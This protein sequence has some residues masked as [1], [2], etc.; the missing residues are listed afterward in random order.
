MTKMITKRSKLYVPYLYTRRKDKSIPVYIKKK[1]GGGAYI[2]VS[3]RTLP[4]KHMFPKNKQN[5]LRQTK[6]DQIKEES[7]VNYTTVTDFHQINLQN[8]H[9]KCVCFV[10]IF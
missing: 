1:K 10:F 2:I 9:K 3:K 6:K 7:N 5:K 8:L 4:F